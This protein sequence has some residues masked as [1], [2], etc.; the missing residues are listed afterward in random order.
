MRPEK[1]M[2]ATK[3]YQS[4]TDEEI[5]T[6]A[7]YLWESDGRVHGRD[8]DYWLQ[9]KAHLTAHREY[10]AGLLQ[11]AEKSLSNKTP[12]L[13]AEI[14]TNGKSAKQRRQNRAVAERVYA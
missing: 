4:P 13:I 5:S 3:N 12:V 10:E 8:V 9:A 7:Y 6:Y 11:K 2:N 1:N 14:S